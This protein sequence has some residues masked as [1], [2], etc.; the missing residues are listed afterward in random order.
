MA[1]TGLDA[2]APEEV[3]A[4]IVA[5]SRDTAETISVWFGEGQGQAGRLRRQV[6]DAVTPL[7][8]GS[9]ALLATGGQV[10]RRAELLRVAA[11]VQTAA[12]GEDAWLTWCAATGL[13]QARHLGGLPEEPDAPARAS[14]WTAP[15][16]P[17]SVTLRQRGTRS[18][19]GRPASVPNRREARRRAR[20]AGDLERAAASRA[21]ESLVARSGSRLADWTPVTTAQEAAL[22]WEVLTTVMRATP[23]RSGA[24]TALTGDDRWRVT[25]A[26]APPDAP[27]AVLNMP[28]GRVACENWLITVRR[29]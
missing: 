22:V 3:I 9:R 10:T 12:T 1:L 20:E 18:T 11:S 4:S 24:R 29:V 26:A 16:V 13:W 23:G 15:A 19:G 25:A 21:E 17:V 5:G 28:E 6:R 7:L 8:R 14:F 27:V 2:T